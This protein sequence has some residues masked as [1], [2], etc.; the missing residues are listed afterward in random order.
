MKILAIA[1]VLTASQ[2]A[3]AQS[4]TV[5]DAKLYE[6]NIDGI[7]NV[8]LFGT[9]SGNGKVTGNSVTGSANGDLVVDSAAYGKIQ[10]SGAIQGT[11][12]FDGKSGKIDAA[13]NGRI[14]G[15]YGIK[16]EGAVDGEGSGNLDGAFYVDG[17]ING[18]ASA[19]GYNL[20]GAAQGTASGKVDVSKLS[21]VNSIEDLGAI[22]KFTKAEAALNGCYTD[23]DGKI[24]CVAYD[25]RGNPNAKWNPVSGK[26]WYDEKL[27]LGQ[28]INGVWV[29]HG[30]QADGSNCFNNLVCA[31]GVCAPTKTD[32]AVKTCL[33][34]TTPT[35]TPKP[36]GGDAGDGSSDAN[37]L[38][39]SMVL[40]AFGAFAAIVF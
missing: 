29:L 39:I 14:S 7:G 17:A 32:P 28:W 12:E 37:G 22:T 35:K 8:K 15:P 40:S 27:Y 38:L 30:S 24:T 36:P 18:D 23:R 10:L 13:A 26:K 6:A 19:F 34:L 33:P 5:K 4:Y 21:K 3:L 16:I 1:S 31:S 2:L 20:R 9:G 25:N 11:G